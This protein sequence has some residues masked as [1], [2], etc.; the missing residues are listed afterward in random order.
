VLQ[1]ERFDPDGTYRRRWVPE[2]DSPAYPRPIVDLAASR[3]AA[4]AAYEVV[5]AAKRG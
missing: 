3:T 5:K 1:A 2:L 4:L